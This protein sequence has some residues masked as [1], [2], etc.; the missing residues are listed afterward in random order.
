MIA[1]SS[2][3]TTAIGPMMVQRKWK[4][5]TLLLMDQI[6]D[7]LDRLIFMIV[8]LSLRFLP[9]LGHRITS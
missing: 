9:S 7:M 1:K 5:G 6:Q 4:M 8:Y 2:L 3:L